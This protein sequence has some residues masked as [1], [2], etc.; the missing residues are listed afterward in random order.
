MAAAE[1]KSE[2]PASAPGS[3]LA[4]MMLAANGALN[5]LAGQAS[6][7]VPAKQTAIKHNVIKQDATAPAAAAATAAAP[8]EAPAA[9]SEDVTLPQDLSSKDAY[10][11]VYTRKGCSFGR[12]VSYDS[13]I[14]EMPQALQDAVR[15]MH[16]GHDRQVAEQVETRTRQVVRFSTG[17]LTTVR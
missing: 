3:S 13:A 16:E 14:G 5:G 10:M 17:E 11:L 9:V 8:A 6:A 12:C 15:A 1:V 7:T 4:D 2:Q